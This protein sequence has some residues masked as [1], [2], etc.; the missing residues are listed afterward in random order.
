M[1][2]G[3][4]RPGRPLAPVVAAPLAI[5]VGWLVAHHS[6]AGWVQVLGDVVFGAVVVGVL[7]PAA[8]LARARVAVTVAPLDG[9]AGRPVRLEVSASTRVR[10][11]PADPPGPDAFAGP[12]G[13]GGPPR[14]AGPARPAR[15][16]AGGT[17]AVTLLPARRGVHDRVVVDLATAAPFG[18]QWWTRRVVLPLPAPLAV[19]PRCGRPAV[20]PPGAGAGDHDAD[21]AAAVTAAAAAATVGDPRGARPYEPGDHRRHVHWGATA[22]TGELM[23]RRHEQPA[24]A[25]R[26]V[27][28][29]LPPDPEAAERAAEAALGALAALLEAGTP[30]VLTTTEAGGRRVAPVADRRDAGRRLAAAVDGTGGGSR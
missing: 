23:V 26:H 18:L 12:V 25:A 8:V 9:T 28:V 15:P 3:R 20:P 6:G 16:A 13:P 1:T 10:V 17:G 7:G 29:T 14:P 5:A 4:L 21:T 30:V 2:G 22:H 11:R 27:A 24:A 19:A